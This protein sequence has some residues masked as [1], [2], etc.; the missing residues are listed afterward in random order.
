MFA[1]TQRL[2][3][4]PGWPEDATALSKALSDEAV[5][6]N[7][8]DID[9]PVTTQAT[10][11][12]LMQ[13]R[14]PLSPQFLLFARTGNAPRLVGGCSIENDEHNEA[15]LNFWIARSYWG[16]G[17]ATEAAQAAIDIAHASGLQ[18]VKAW[19]TDDNVAAA[20]VLTKLGFSPTG[21]REKRYIAAR[22]A[23]IPCLL[24]K[25]SGAKPARKD[26]STDLYADRSI[27][28]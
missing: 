26:P 24:F 3:L 14:D 23:D 21:K 11:A 1:R 19:I 25:D 9:G 16:L 15:M 7:L 18:N 4:R 22:N 12:F 5:T 27:A 8:P 28:A 6:R 2:L 13:A 20:H 10:Q 17:F